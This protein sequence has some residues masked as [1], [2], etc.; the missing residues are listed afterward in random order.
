MEMWIYAG[1]AAHQPKLFTTRFQGALARGKSII[2]GRARDAH[3]ANVNL[4]EKS[5][6]FFPSLKRRHVEVRGLVAG[7]ANV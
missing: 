3:S 5:A 7:E 1:E 2:I 6:V 4:A